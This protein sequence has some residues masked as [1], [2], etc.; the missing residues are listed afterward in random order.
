VRDA[1]TSHNFFFVRERVE[2]DAGIFQIGLATRALMRVSIVESVQETPL[3]HDVAQ[4]VSMANPVFAL[5]KRDEMVD[6]SM[7]RERV[8]VWDIRSQSDGIRNCGPHRKIK[9]N[10]K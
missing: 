3:N 9:D 4:E 8:M 2:Y 10:F 5:A 1:V 7:E 6:A